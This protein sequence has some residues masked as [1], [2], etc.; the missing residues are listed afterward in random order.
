MEGSDALPPPPAVPAPAPAPAAA[1]PVAASPEAASQ[2]TVEVL[3]LTPAPAAPPAAASA[4]PGP[5]VEVLPLGPDTAGDTAAA[6][7]PAR[8]NM[9]PAAAQTVP[10]LPRAGAGG[11]SS[12]ASVSWLL[13]GLILLSGGVSVTVLAFTRR[14]WSE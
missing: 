1:A 10:A 2:P 9:A 3:P 4:T 8:P 11:L 7:P 6:P 13:L 12:A 14:R 5:L